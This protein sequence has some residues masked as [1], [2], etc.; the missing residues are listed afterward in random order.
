M[1]RA[2]TV[3]VVVPSP[4]ASFVLL[5]TSWTRLCPDSQGVCMYGHG[6]TDRAPR[7]CRSSSDGRCTAMQKKQTHL[8]LVLKGDGLCDSHA[9]LGD[10]WACA[11]MSQCPH[12]RRLAA[13]TPPYGCSMTT[14]LP[15]GPSV[16]ETAFA[17]ISTPASID[18]RAS[19]ENCKSR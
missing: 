18:A 10:L 5:A 8:D 4:A 9:V 11:S 7:F 16:T 15:R 3:A 6:G 17:R 14:V 13:A 1:A 2:R 12:P 19:L